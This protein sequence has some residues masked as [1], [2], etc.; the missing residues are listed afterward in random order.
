MEGTPYCVLEKKGD[1]WFDVFF[2]LM[3]WWFDG[4]MVGWFR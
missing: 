3:V 1:G 2:G 4:W